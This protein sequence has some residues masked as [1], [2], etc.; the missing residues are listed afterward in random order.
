MKLVVTERAFVSGGIREPGTVVDI[1][2]DQYNPS[3]D[4]HLTPYVE[5]PKA[6]KTKTTEPAA[7]PAEL[8]GQ[9]KLTG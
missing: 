7:K 5:P 4:K 8:L 9:P 2:D 6:A 1:P 3:R